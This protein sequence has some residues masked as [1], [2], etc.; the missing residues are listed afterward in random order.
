MNESSSEWLA[1]ALSLPIRFALVREDPRID[2]EALRTAQRGQANVVLVGS[3]G[4]T[5]AFLAAQPD[6]ASLTVVD[7]NPAQLALCQLKIDLLRSDS[8]VERECLLGHQP[9][10]DR[11]QRIESRLASLGLPRDAL[12]PI[13]TVSKLGPDESGRYERLFAA[14]RDH[15]ADRTD[16]GP[17]W[18]AQSVSEQ[19]ALV[20]SERPLG[21][22][23]DAA[24]DEIF[25]LQNLVALF[26]EEATQNPRVSFATHFATRL[27]LELGQR[28]ARENPFVVNLLGDPRERPPV[29]P[30]WIRKCP[31]ARPEIRYVQNDMLGFLEAETEPYD[32]VHLSNITDW[33][34]ESRAR[35]V[36]AAARA[37]LRPG[38]VVII[39]QLNSS[40]DLTASL[41]DFTLWA[42]EIDRVQRDRSFFYRRVIIATR[43]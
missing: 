43:S 31:A 36:M 1:Q 2:L 15:I 10:H 39:R 11:Q 32:V 8:Q 22:A 24:F 17:L 5:A 13:E 27:R 25:S 28:L 12:G 3:G 35:Q 29:V 38:G 20:A 7:P 18:S 41:N 4:C 30:D 42:N 40:L 37:R 21:S 9:C 26:G 33:L 23:I 6:V 16:L 19:Q 34:S 14:L